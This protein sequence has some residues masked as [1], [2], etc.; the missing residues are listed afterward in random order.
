MLYRV[1]KHV[2]LLRERHLCNFV[3]I[4]I[5]KT[6]GSSIEHALGLRVRH[7][8]ALELRQRLGARHWERKFRFAFVRNPWDKVAS[9]YRYRVRSNRGGLGD[10]PIPFNEWVSRAYEQRDPAYFDSPR[11]FMEQVDWISD[12][13]DHSLVSFVGRFENLEEDFAHVC[14]AIGRPS[15]RLPHLNPSGLTDFRRHYDDDTAAIVARRFARDI[16]RFGYTFD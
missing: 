4:H 1:S 6:G 11:W 10:N 13:D 5:N 14:A 15:L 9:H 7:W 12:G 2:E 3:F 8:T 16:D